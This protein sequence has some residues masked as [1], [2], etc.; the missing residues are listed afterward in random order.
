MEPEVQRFEGPGEMSLGAARLVARKA[1]AAIAQRGAFTLA[2]S[3]GSTPRGLYE[4]LAREPFSRGIDWERVHLFWGDERR[5]PEES[6]ASNFGLARREL[7]EN[8]P[9]PPANV[10]PMPGEM[11]PAR[12]AA[13]A[14]ET[15]LARVFRVE[16]PSFPRFDLILL[17]VGA[18][19]HTASLFPGALSLREK[20]RWVVAVEG[21]GASSPVGR[22]T[23]TLPVI[24]SSRG[25]VFLVSGPGKGE[26]L[27]TILKR[28]DEARGLYPAALVRPT[29]GELFWLVDGSSV[30]LEG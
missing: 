19:G 7:L 22:L 11:D 10:H 27:E 1:G 5:V 9:V 28:P 24:N 21:A 16:P 12:D 26:V 25:A 2:L 4:R 20:K 23:L 17:G 30:H 13:R 15:E 18:D 29:R 14:Y 3:G 8:I 6:P